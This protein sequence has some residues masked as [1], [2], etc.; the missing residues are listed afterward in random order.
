MKK[1]NLLLIVFLSTIVIAHTQPP[2]FKLLLTPQSGFYYKGATDG[3]T[4]VT[5]LRGVL[6]YQNTGSGMP[7]NY[8]KYGSLRYTYQPVLPTSLVNSNMQLICGFK[9]D[10][11]LRVTVTYEVLANMGKGALFSLTD[12][13]GKPSQ[14]TVNNQLTDTYHNVTLEAKTV[15]QEITFFFSATKPIVDLNPYFVLYVLIEEM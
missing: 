2:K 10:M 1:L 7:S 3:A 15:N 5:Y 13:I 14:V 12:G 4:V 6:E 9:K 8:W 11:Q